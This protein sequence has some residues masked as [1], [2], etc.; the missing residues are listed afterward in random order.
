MKMLIFNP[1][2]SID[3]EPTL[4]PTDRSRAK[5]QARKRVE[6]LQRENEGVW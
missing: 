3:D 6:E 5:P 2:C 1:G 4:T